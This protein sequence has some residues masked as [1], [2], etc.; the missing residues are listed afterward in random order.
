MWIG[1]DDMSTS[2]DFSK[3]ISIKAMYEEMGDIKTRTEE[4]E[5]PLLLDRDLL[6]DI[7]RLFV[8][9]MTSRGRYPSGHMCRREFLFIALYLY[10][11][12]SL[13][14]G[15]LPKGL[16]DRLCGI[17]GIKSKS[18]IS[19]SCLNLIFFY[20]EYKDFRENV[21]AI[22]ARI[23]SELLTNKKNEKEK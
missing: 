10:S 2:I 5:A 3:I 12:R 1:I 23:S 14:G 21:D 20:Q 22:Y 6:P 4:M 7:Y 17:M 8:D 19:D 18:S 16:R 13:A 9:E 15:R 11:P